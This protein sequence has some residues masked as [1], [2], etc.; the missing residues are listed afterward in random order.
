MRLLLA[1]RPTLRSGMTLVTLTALAVGC[2]SKPSLVPERQAE[3]IQIR[4]RALASHAGAIQDAIRQS[5]TLGALAFIDN[6]NGGL[7]ILPGDTPGDAWARHHAAGTPVSVPPV[8]DFVYRPDIAK[9]PDTVTHRSLEEQQ[10]LRA[11]LVAIDAE[12]RKLSDSIAA[13]RQE[14][15]ASLASARQDAQKSLDELAD[16]LAAARK[17]M[18]QT[19]QLGWLDHEL[20]AENANAL[21]KLNATSQDLTATSTRLAETIQHLS[22]TLNRQLKDLAARLDAIQNR[23][24]NVK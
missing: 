19:A 8:V 15:Q 3:S 12:M 9:A 24:S 1:A 13:T 20:V 4:E 17:F 7:V 22:D 2:A 18:L 16:D 23:V 10:Q 21:R 6:A 5:N 14:A 11:T